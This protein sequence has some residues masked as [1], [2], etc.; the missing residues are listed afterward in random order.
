[1]QSIPF[2]SLLHFFHRFSAG[3][4]RLFIVLFVVMSL[5][6]AW[7]IYGMYQGADAGL[8]YG[9]YEHLTYHPVSW[10]QVSADHTLLHLKGNAVTRYGIQL[11]GMLMGSDTS[12]WMWFFFMVMGW[13]AVLSAA[14]RLQTYWNLIPVFLFAMWLRMGGAGELLFG[15][16]PFYLLT[17]LIACVFIA[18]I[19]YFQRQAHRTAV[20]VSFLVYAGLL[21]LLFALLAWKGGVAMVSV[22]QAGTM[23]F[24]YL[25][26]CGTILYLSR[27]PILLIT[28][29][30]TNQPKSTQRASLPI[31]LVVWGLWLLLL[32]YLLLRFDSF[33]ASPVGVIL[34][35]MLLLISIASAPFTAQNGYHVLKHVYGSNIA[36]TLN[37]LAAGTWTAA[38]LG[39]AY[40]SGEWLVIHQTDRIITSAF[41]LM[42]AMQVL[43]I[44]INFYPLL[45]QKTNL[46]F[47]LQMPVK[48]RFFI[49]WLTLIV[50]LS[51]MEGFKSWKS[52]HIL[53]AVSENQVA[54]AQ[55]RIG[56]I[57]SARVLYINALGYTSGDPKANYNV[58]L[59]SLLPNTDPEAAIQKLRIA[60]KVFPQFKAGDLQA[61]WHLNFTGK[62]KEAMDILD[63]RYRQQPDAITANTLAWYYHQ[64]S[65]PDSAIV[66]LKYAL[67]AEPTFADGYANLAYIYLENNKPADADV[68]LS[69]AREVSDGNP[70]ANTNLLY[71]Q[72]KTGVFDST[73]WNDDWLQASVSEGFLL[74]AMYWNHA[75]ANLEFSDRI[76]ARLEESAPGPEVLLYRAVRC[77]QTDSIPQALSRHAWIQRNH[78]RYAPWSA[79]NMATLYYAQG[80]PEMAEKIIAEYAKEEN[81][82]AIILRGVMQALTGHQD[83]AYRNF[84]LARI[85]PDTT[86]DYARKECALIL[87][88]NGQELY[89][90]YDW[91]FTDAGYHDWIR[92]ARY[93]MVATKTAQAIEMLRNAIRLDSTRYE[94]YAL[95]ADWMLTQND[96]QAISIYQDGLAVFPE[97]PALRAGY[98]RAL[99]A[100]GQQALATTT[101]NAWT[102]QDTSEAQLV[103]ML[104]EELS[105]AGKPAEAIAVL[106]R[107]HV[108]HPMDIRI[109][110]PL[111][112][113]L[114]DAGDASEAT[115]WIYG[116]L[117]VN[118]QNPDLWYYYALLATRAGYT[119]QAGFGA[120]KT[121]SFLSDAAKKKEIELQFATEIQAWRQSDY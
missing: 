70:D 119:E 79:H 96:S 16:D 46:Y 95:L 18:T 27:E 32:L 66:C 92:G 33:L 29:F 34:P 63:A 54:D 69:H 11:P 120:I 2:V 26:T 49:V 37:H 53:S 78:S 105:L 72:L 65:M 84:S 25:I 106:N 44:T 59:L 85:N 77:M 10:G 86:A 56:N 113:A 36:F 8:G 45:K 97:H 41:L 121:L 81:T 42:G 89:A 103:L 88:A 22:F 23:P 114:S 28:A 71:A 93:A 1:M 94:P 112:Q 91:D 117:E 104:S 17:L 7:A 9:V 80:A 82:S 101:R 24:F 68:F 108:K 76:A 110:L 51:I 118:D 14:S 90:T 74:N 15:T 13:A 6:L 109:I 64:A 98:I 35:T 12:I 102:I 30:L 3:S 115:Q 116:L 38:T 60:G 55:Y 20:W 50:S 40:A 107:Y 67:D 31:L 73:L 62:R 39:Y 83:S 57:D 52:M 5:A 58:G 75:S 100:A 48:F 61:A 4:K 19:Y 99:R 87:Y 43:Y 111:A 21:S 47:V